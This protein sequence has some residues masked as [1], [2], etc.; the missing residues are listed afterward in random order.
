MRNKI[1]HKVCVIPSSGEQSSLEAGTKRTA[2][3]T[4]RN[5]G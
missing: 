4:L 5:A 1:E 3:P 2:H